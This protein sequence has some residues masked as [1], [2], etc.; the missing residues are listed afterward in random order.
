MTREVGSPTG[1]HIDGAREERAPSGGPGLMALAFA[2][3]MALHGVVHVV[4]FTLAWGL[5]APKGAAYSTTLF[6]GAVD[7]GDAGAKLLG[8]V[9]LATAAAFLGV[10]VMLWRGHAL[11]L[12]ATV[13]V[14]TF[15][16][17]LCTASLPEPVIGLGIDVVL[18]ATLAV[19]RDRL[20]PSRVR[21]A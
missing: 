14:L 8:I 17:A 10:A 18:L 1:S 6:A 19:A 12:P 16:L 3:F 15:S 9:W 5:G 2:A 21:P 11:A 7:V 20:I 13:A 4:G